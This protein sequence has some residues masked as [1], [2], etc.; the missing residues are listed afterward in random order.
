MK[1]LLLKTKYGTKLAKKIL[2]NTFYVGLTYFYVHRGKNKLFAKW[3][4]TFHRWAHNLFSLKIENVKK[5]WIYG[6]LMTSVNDIHGY[7]Q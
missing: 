2:I 4:F 6:K 1:T 5:L 3:R 7:G